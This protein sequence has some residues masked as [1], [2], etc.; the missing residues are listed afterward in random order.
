[1]YYL[2]KFSKLIRKILV[3]SSEKENSLDDELDTMQLYMNIENIRFSNEINFEI[4]IDEDINTAKIK[5]PSLILQPFLENALWHGLSS[6]KDDK[7]ILL[8]VYR[9][10]DDFVT[11]AVTDN[12]IGR[13]E[14]D[15]INQDKLLKRKSVG[16]AIT[17]ARLANFSKG[18]TNDYRIEV[19]DLYDDNE[20]PIGTRVIVEIPTRSNVLRTA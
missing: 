16:I 1:V 3:A 9:T 20:K 7:H 19:E 6:K 8:H 2:N 5:V 18:Y 13:K 14:A 10:E 4:R 17:K 11:I 12:G 15:K